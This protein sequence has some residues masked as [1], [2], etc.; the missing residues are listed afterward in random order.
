[1][2]AIGESEFYQ[3]VVLRLKEREKELQCIYKV[4]EILRDS[5]RRLDDVFKA[6]LRVIP[7][8]WQHP[9]LCETRI[10]FEG[11]VIRSDDFRETAWWLKSDIVLDDNV[12]GRLDLV[13]TQKVAEE[14]K[15][16]FLPEEQKL[17]NTIAESLS[18]HIFI[19]RLR[20]TLKTI[21]SQ[22]TPKLEKQVERILS[23]DSDLH[24]K[25]RARQ[26]ELISH[27]MDMERFGVQAVYVIGSTKNATAGPESDI[28]LLIH[29]QGDAQQRQCLEA[30]LEAWSLSLAEI[31]FLNTGHRPA[32]GMLDVHL[33]TDEDIRK[34]T[35]YA[36]MIGSTENGAKLLK[37]RNTS[38]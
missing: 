11:K 29:F 19:R 6:V 15:A 1:M 36:V 25:W 4:E 31:S 30:W 13:Y 3:R 32:R 33:V 16:V 38:S 20:A 34:K 10:I 17:L 26:A 8:G 12:A 22:P 5:E 18:H 24:W 23:P 14:G 21:R 9:T 2:E 28:D 37:S 7:S 35:S 27:H